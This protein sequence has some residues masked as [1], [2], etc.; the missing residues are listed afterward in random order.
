[1]IEILGLVL[2]DNTAKTAHL[3]V[4]LS[5]ILFH[6]EEELQ[7]PGAE[8]SAENNASWLPRSDYVQ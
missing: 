5:S 6:D 4:F 3:A 2:V 1:L 7:L 8:N